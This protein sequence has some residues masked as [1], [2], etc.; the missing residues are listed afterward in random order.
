MTTKTKKTG[1]GGARPGSGRPAKVSGGRYV[2]AKLGDE[3]LEK[4]EKIRDRIAELGEGSATVPD[5]IRFV[6]D[7]GLDYIDA[8]DAEGHDLFKPEA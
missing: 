7:R 4:L 5:A 6:L 8:H 3:Q 2:N 1:R